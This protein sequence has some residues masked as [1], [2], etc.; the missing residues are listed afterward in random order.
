M[1][2]SDA[3]VSSAEAFVN[4]LAAVFNVQS[5]GASSVAF[6]VQP[7]QA[8]V[9]LPL[10]T[11]VLEGDLLQPN[12][13]AATGLVRRPPA[14]TN[15]R[16]Q[17]IPGVAGLPGLP[18]VPTVQSVQAAALLQNAGLAPAAAAGA[19]PALPAAV[20]VGAET[21]IS[22]TAAA[23]PPASTSAQGAALDQAAM[24]AA[25]VAGL[26]TQLLAAGGLSAGTVMMPT[27]ATAAQIAGGMP[28][29][30]AIPVLLPTQQA[31]GSAC[32]PSIST[33]SDL[34]Q[35]F[36]GLLSPVSTASTVVPSYASEMS[37]ATLKSASVASSMISTPPSMADAG[38]AA[39]AATATAAT[40]HV[41]KKVRVLLSSG[42]EYEE[43][44][45]T[46]SEPSGTR[47][48]H[49]RYIGG[50]TRLVGLMPTTSFSHF[51][52]QLSKATAAVWDE[53][54]R[55][56]YDLP[57]ADGD[58]GTL[59]D[60]IDD[61]DL[62]MM[63]EEL[64]V[65]MAVKPGFKLHIYAQLSSKRGSAGGSSSTCASADSHVT[66]TQ[67]SNA[68]GGSHGGHNSLVGSIELKVHPAHAAAPA[69]TATPSGC[70]PVVSFTGTE[71]DKGSY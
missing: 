38:I 5:M 63:W 32:A 64:E 58:G 56:M 16:M 66:K 36:A 52:Q 70:S 13:P 54:C 14:K 39:A 30:Q 20:P 48:G 22:P 51:L 17:L 62:E 29:M 26:N 6:P 49:W 28:A 65:V 40:P 7:L 37:M 44:P 21:P 41:Q 46:G 55:L 34:S 50:E 67:D 19:V 4:S 45:P 68:V 69:G 18:V 60:L 59:V 47:A 57:G 42:G 11:P 43:L 15:S 10:P 24:T 61:E 12:P 2:S 1:D 3:T 35:H 53:G 31:A 71:R 9:C 33:A 27:G 25:T 23:V 8:P